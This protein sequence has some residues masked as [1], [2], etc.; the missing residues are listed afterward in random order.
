MMRQDR[1]SIEFRITIKADEIIA[2]WGRPGDVPDTAAVP[3]WT[4]D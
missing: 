2:R 1:R 4:V 3:N